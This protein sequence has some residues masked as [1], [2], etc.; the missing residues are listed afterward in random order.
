[1]ANDACPYRA[2]THTF[3]PVRN[4][5]KGIHSTPR[6]VLLVLATILCFSLVVNSSWKPTPDSSLYLSLGES[7]ARGDGYVFDGQPHT[8]VSPGFPAMVAAAAWLFGDNFLVYRIGMALMGLLAALAGYLLVLRLCGRDTALLAGGLFAVNHV[9]LHNST[10][11][12]SDV[13]FALFAL[14]ALHAALS[15]FGSR[16]VWIPTIAAGLIAGVLPMIR[17][18]GMGVPPAIAF[19]FLFTESACRD[20][21][22][23]ILQTTIF[24]ALAY[25]PTVL[26][27]CWKATVPASLNEGTYAYTV[28]GRT[29]VDQATVVLGTLLEYVPETSYALTGA[30]LRTGILESIVPLFVAVGLVSAWRRGDRLLVPLTLIQYCGLLLS[31]A[32][33]RYLIFLLPGLYIFM[34]L[35][36][37]RSAT[38]LSDRYPALRDRLPSTRKLVLGCFAFL[39]LLNMG[40]NCV[41]IFQARTALEAYGPESERRADFFRA[42]HWLKA[43]APD[44]VVLTMHPR[45]IH[46]LS[47]CPTVP[48][49]RSGVPQHEVW[50]RDE[51]TIR[52]LIRDRH[53]TFL[54]T[55]SKNV[56]FYDDV[57]K[58]ITRAGY[59]LEEVP[60]SMNSSRHRLWKIIYPADLIE[61]RRES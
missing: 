44:S 18:N 4:L 22:T 50:V 26:W 33:S 51:P 43:N 55:D 48:L 20:R 24:L 9:L 27:E 25:L 7:L 11:T 41:T 29:F 46:Y 6:I 12:I 14:L 58:A 59:I 10:L 32:G 42:A 52:K 23:R 47:G 54:F 2:L 15:S 3:E 35:G 16:R 30:A 19:F 56:G 38:F 28:L 21:R 5:V 39:A 34:A 17:I 45:V 53:P 40:H 37:I 8:L 60:A 36:M 61:N 57:M 13:P 1:M 49:L 31:S